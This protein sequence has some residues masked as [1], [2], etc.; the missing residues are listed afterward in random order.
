M[1]S[2]DPEIP[3]AVM[4]IP[5]TSGSALHS[6]LIRTIKPG[7]FKH[8]Y[9][10]VLFGTF[11]AFK[12]MSPEIRQQIFLNWEDLPPRVDMV[13]GHFAFS[14]LQSRY[15]NYQ[16]MTFL[17][18]PYSRILSH[19][20][21]W[22]TQRDDELAGWGD[23]GTDYVRLARQP[24]AQFLVDATLAGQIDNLCT[25]MLLWPHPN[26]PDSGFIDERH[27]EVLISTALARLRKFHYVDVV[28]NRDRITGLG[29]WL[30]QQVVVERVNETRLCASAHVTH[31]SDEL[32][33]ETRALLNARSRL[34]LVLWKVVSQHRGPFYRPQLIQER[35]VNESTKHF[36]RL[37][38][39]PNLRLV[40]QPKPLARLANGTSRN[41][42]SVASG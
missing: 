32:T 31:I 16:F 41:K 7:S 35:V 9:D 38:R 11:A 8:G 2:Y 1:A 39:G 3:I 19:W 6:A 23:W 37:M 34:D 40:H 26:I 18:E 13:H 14:T 21:Y 29:R 25:R 24:L 5:K 36:A 27:D 10:G 17:R 42:V 22:R 28:E 15:P 12:S 4:H 33:R 30:G 20:L